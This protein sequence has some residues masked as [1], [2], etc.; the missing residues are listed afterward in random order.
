[1]I[2]TIYENVLYASFIAMYI[3]SVISFFSHS[4][5]G[6]EYKNYNIARN[7]FSVAMVIWGTYIA[8]QWY[9]NI[10]STDSLLAITLNFSCHYLGGMLLEFMFSLLLLGCDSIH[11]RIKEIVIRV[12]LFNVALCLNYLFV[13]SSW[14]QTGIIVLALVFVIEIAQLTIHFL[15]IYRNII[16]KTDNYYSDNVGKHLNWMPRSINLT[17]IFGFL[18][19]VLSFAPKGMIAMYLFLG[20]LLFTYIFISFQNYMIN[21][22]NIKEVILIDQLTKLQIDSLNPIIDK[23]RKQAIASGI[24]KKDKAEKK[25]NYSNIDEKTKLWIAKKGFLIQG[26]TIEEV[27]F[28]FSTNRTY[29]SSYINST[30]NYSFREWIAQNRIAYS[31]ELLCSNKELQLSKIAEMVGYSS[32]AFNA[33]FIKINKATP[34][35]WRSD[36]CQ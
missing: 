35:Q 6:A 32:S 18:G 30:Y 23:E 27:A 11:K 14:Q 22:V 13:P 19:S 5:R 2:Q 20:M 8:I 16:L 29:L 4:P 9:F 36:N 7:V 24:N 10:R 12:F 25:K 33:A 31:Q 28:E 3:F 1:M 17:I 15:K 26:V 34:S 21:I